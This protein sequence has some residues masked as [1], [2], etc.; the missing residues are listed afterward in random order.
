MLV[1][2]LYV[3]ADDV[4]LVM[5]VSIGGVSV[6]CADALCFWC[7]CYFVPSTFILLFSLTNSYGCFR[8]YSSQ[9][10]FLPLALSAPTQSARPH[11]QSESFHG[12]KG[13]PGYEPDTPNADTLTQ[14]VT[15]RLLGR[16]LCFFRVDGGG[17]GGVLAQGFD[18]CG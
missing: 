7:G 9:P 11:G 16:R 3:V 5:I 12:Y 18:V 6:T 17:G 15:G 13:Y 4:V 8:C 2:S 14:Q 1:L 10:L